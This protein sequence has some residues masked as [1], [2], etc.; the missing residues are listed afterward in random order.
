MLFILL[1]QFHYIAQAVFKWPSLLPELLQCWGQNWDHRNGWCD[2]FVIGE[3]WIQCS[4]GSPDSC[5]LGLR[6][7]LGSKHMPLWN[8]SFTSP[9]KQLPN[10]Q[11]FHILVVM[12]IIYRYK[13]MC[14]WKH[15]H[16]LVNVYY[17][18]QNWHRKVQCRSWWHPSHTAGSINSM[19]Q[20]L[21][22]RWEQATMKTQSEHS[23]KPAML[24]GA[25]A[26]CARPQRGWQEWDKE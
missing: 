15:N 18:P 22:E 26:V 25:N 9:K 5:L 19:W 12:I 3:P 24:C 23:C 16:H 4:W 14:T 21:Q 8:L 7:G 11:G 17:S 10:I 6:G 13:Y 1:T 20:G 2:G